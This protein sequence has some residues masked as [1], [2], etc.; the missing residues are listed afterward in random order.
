MM[1]KVREGNKH[2]QLNIKYHSIS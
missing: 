2:L 1:A